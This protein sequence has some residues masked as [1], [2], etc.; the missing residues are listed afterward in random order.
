ME[1]GEIPRSSR[2]KSTKQ[3]LCLKAE[4]LK[5]LCSIFLTSW[6]A[7]SA[8]GSP[9]G[10]QPVSEAGGGSRVPVASCPHPSAP[11]PATTPVFASNLW[12]K[13]WIQMEMF[14][15][16]FCLFYFISF[17]FILF[18]FWWRC[19]WGIGLFCFRLWFSKLHTSHSICTYTIFPLS[20][21]HKWNYTLVINLFPFHPFLQVVGHALRCNPKSEHNQKTC[22]VRLGLH[23]VPSILHGSFS[24]TFAVFTKFVQNVL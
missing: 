16:S 10:F 14:L 23:W 13:N 5:A 2:L 18:Y 7:V 24:D 8:W 22:G 17:Y 12:V 20:F 1:R 11:G 3:S 6:Q 19:A 9:V 4:L 15:Y 21:P